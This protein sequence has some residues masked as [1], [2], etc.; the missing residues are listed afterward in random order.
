MLHTPSYLCVVC[1]Q[2]QEVSL[3]YFRSGYTPRDYPSEDEWTARRMMECSNA[4][5]V[6]PSP[7]S[8]ACLVA[9]T[10]PSYCEPTLMMVFFIFI[11]DLALQ[12]PS[13]GQQLC[14]AKK[15]QQVLTQDGMVERFLANV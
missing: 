4:I 2:N 10:H 13:V 11:F 3:I 14:G 6:Q 7:F 1:A 8:A 9:A 12:V 5:K 15:I